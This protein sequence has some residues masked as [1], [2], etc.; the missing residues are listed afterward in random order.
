MTLNTRRLIVAV[1]L[2]EPL[3]VAGMVGPG[4]VAIST[5]DA[6]TTARI[7]E[8]QRLALWTA[9]TAGFVLCLLGG[10][11]VARRASAGHERNGFV[12][13]I[14]VAT[15]DLGLLIASGAPFG[16]LMVTS[17]T[18]RLAGGWCGGLLAKRRAAT[19]HSAVHA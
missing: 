4:F 13:G 9:P 6:A 2:A 17:A 15:I 7:L 1:P 5:L 10:W 18:G 11:W 14:A 3:A 12:L 8:V 16:L 19:N